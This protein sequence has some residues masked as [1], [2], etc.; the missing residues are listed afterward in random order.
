[1]IRPL[2]AI[3]L[4]LAVFAAPTAARATH[5]GNSAIT[6][7]DGYPVF[8]IDGKP[9]FPYGAAFFYERLP[10][11][12]WRD[13]MSRLRELGINTLDLY[14]PW[15]WHEL[16][17]GDFDFNGRTNPRRDL[18]HLMRLAREFGFKIILRPGPVIRNEWRNGSYPDWLL[19]RPEY[20]MPLHDLL[21]GRY[22]PTATLQNAHSDDAAAQWM[23]NATH[24]RYA[25]RWLTR[26][27]REFMPVADLVIAVQLDDDQGAYIDN[28]TWPAPH[29]QA[30]LQRLES[31]VHGV[32][33]PAQLVFIN[34]YDMKVTAS[35]PAWAM[36]NW[37]QSAAYAIGDHDR[38]E[39]EF[40]TGLLQTQADAPLMY[41]EFQAGWLQQPGDSRPRPTDP[42]NTVLA[43]GT[44]LGMGTHGIVNFPAQ[45]TLN[46]AGMEAPFANASY[47]W[48]AALTLDG[49]RSARY[50]PTRRIG[51][52]VQ[53]YGT[54]LAGAHVL[55][56]AGVAYLTSAFDEKSIDDGDVSGIATRTR[57]AQ[58]ACRAYS[59]SC[60]LVDLRFASDAA[61][62]RYPLLI[63]PMPP[64]A[65]H[66][67]SLNPSI[68]DALARYARDGGVILALGRTPGRPLPGMTVVDALNRQIVDRALR[69]AKHE[70]VIADAPGASFVSN[71]SANE[72]F[73]I[74][75]N[76][77]DKPRTYDALTIVPDGKHRITLRNLNVAARDLVVAPIAL[78]GLTLPTPTL[79]PTSAPPDTTPKKN[80][81]LPALAPAPAGRAQAFAMDVYRDGNKAIVL[82]NSLVRVIIAPN[83]GAR[84]FVFE[85]LAKGVNAFTTVG[86]LRDDVK[87]EP[88]LSTADKIA[89]YT[90]QFPAGMFN[91][92]YRAEIVGRGNTA[93]ARFSY[94]A[95]D[96]V[97][98][99][100]HFERI[101]TL[102]PDARSF[103]VDQTVHF[104]DN[105]TFGQR[106]VCVTSLAAYRALAAQGSAL[107]FYDPD[108]HESV[109]VSW[110]AG[111]TEDARV[112]ERDHSVVVRLTLAANRTARV[113][114][115]FDSP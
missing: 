38:T 108:S 39:L 3:V 107:H 34:T 25:Q 58:R 19:R 94:D 91:R 88:P 23:N 92:P 46:P 27:L 65:P 14:V 112:L 28:Q 53:A 78:S 18:D 20:A 52:L 45:D 21:E 41:S 48:D 68:L 84:A 1:M 79:S 57:Q 72:G 100:A 9:F 74:L 75:S 96:V 70:R 11:D 71:P 114:Y 86:A 37:Y 104:P 63:L 47:A 4:A 60:G 98:H 103:T 85:D 64:R 93:S 26:V 67:K 10:R 31:I 109:T 101:I 82:Q 50:A 43:M 15:N 111:D 73:F 49:L 113:T 81:L 13:S 55:F 99:G 36:G 80:L 44:L 17:D 16:R 35:S 40:A 5:Y 97:P 42:A 29:L 62:R 24:M 56:D 90:H 77:D 6:Q 33:G 30:Y 83:A 76:Y 59:L 7:R 66:L 22:P 12:M 87:I 2:I 69:E 8:T 115:G 95:P 102:A 110:H 89:K 32:T 51:D 105:Q 106:A 54:Q 61:L